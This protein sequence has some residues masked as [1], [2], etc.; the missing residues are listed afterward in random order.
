MF[1]I[2]TYTYKDIKN[3]KKRKEYIY[4]LDNIYKK[5]KLKII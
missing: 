4:I 1:S 3:K 2:P 5:I